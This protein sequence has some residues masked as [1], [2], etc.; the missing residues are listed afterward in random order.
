M[1]IVGESIKI[2]R[3]QK[4]QRQGRRGEWIRVSASR[5]GVD[6][7][8][9]KT[10]KSK[11]DKAA[12]NIE[13]KIYNARGKREKENSKRNGLDNLVIRADNEVSNL[14]EIDPV[15]TENVQSAQTQRKQI[16][17]KEIKS[18]KDIRQELDDVRIQLQKLRV[19]RYDERDNA[20]KELDTFQMKEQAF[21]AIDHEYHSIEN[22]YQKKIEE[23][24]LDKR[25]S[26]HPHVLSGIEMEK[27][28]R[29]QFERDSAGVGHKNPYEFEQRVYYQGVFPMEQEQDPDADSSKN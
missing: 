23:S 19:E 4:P 21:W 15:S 22:T 9:R 28:R 10:E 16:L 7:P 2:L 12:V 6:L 13:T 5:G 1:K 17:H 24:N 18:S 8:V 3:G 26:E 11:S 29:L 27:Q 25:I 20:H 14:R